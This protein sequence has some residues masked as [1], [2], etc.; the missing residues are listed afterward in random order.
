MI[1]ELAAALFDCTHRRAVGESRDRGEVETLAAEFGEVVEHH[2]Q[3]DRLGDVEEMGEDVGLRHREKHRRHD[4]DG[5]Q[6]EGLRVSP[7]VDGDAGPEVRNVGDH[8]Q[9][10]GEF[11]N[12][13]ESVFAFVG[14]KMGKLTR[15]A[16]AKHASDA[17][18]LL[19]REVR[20]ERRPVE[21]AGRIGGQ[22]L[23]R[24]D[25]AGTVG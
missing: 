2:G 22:P 21:A 5:G 11:G 1:S 19:K 23:G 17:G 24:V 25:A 10:R 14:R 9:R 3:F 15:A 6:A 8:R 7:E 13:G 16:E 20:G 12:R 18:G 4:G